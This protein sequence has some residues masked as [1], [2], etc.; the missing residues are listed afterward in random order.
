MSP[1]DTREMGDQ[2]ARGDDS[3]V[4]CFLARDD[5][6]HRLLYDGDDL[7]QKEHAVV[8][9]HQAFGSS[10]AE[11]Q[12]HAPVLLISQQA[13]LEEPKR[14]KFNLRYPLS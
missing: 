10:L 7:G 13:R 9:R 11:A 5:R 2:D 8:T 4:P 3:V 12:N 1:S 6:E 14:S